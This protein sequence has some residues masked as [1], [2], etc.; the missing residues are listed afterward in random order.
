MSA[1][2]AAT[3]RPRQINHHKDRSCGFWIK[4][5][6]VAAFA[7]LFF[8]RFNSTF[9]P[10]H[11]NIEHR[12]SQNGFPV[13]YE[14]GYHIVPTPTPLPSWDAR[15]L[16]EKV[17]GKKW[18]Y[19]LNPY[20]LVPIHYICIRKREVE[21]FDVD[22]RGMPQNK[23][24]MRLLNHTL[25]VPHNEFEALLSYAARNF[26]DHLLTLLPEQRDYFLVFPH[27]KKSERWVAELLLRYLII[28][29]LDAT[30]IDNLQASLSKYPHVKRIVIADDAAY[31]CSSMSL[32]MAKTYSYFGPL[33]IHAIIPL[34]SSRNCL[35]DSFKEMLSYPRK[36]QPHEAVVHTALEFGSKLS[37]T[38]IFQNA[39]SATVLWLKKQGIPSPWLERYA[40]AFSHKL[41]DHFSI[42]RELYQLDNALGQDYVFLED[43]L[44]PYKDAVGTIELDSSEQQ[45][46]TLLVNEMMQP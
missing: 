19:E 46:V 29:P 36:P 13:C 43:P 4:A 23:P 25:V 21:R 1:A 6:I 45:L 26:T 11:F 34:M 28:L 39:D 22:A 17:K 2:I 35:H 20:P 42:P 12:E 16:T 15:A 41:P 40:L 27:P 24:V 8:S 10:Q 32:L 5:L 44:P 9:E 31:S 14:E 37:M 30:L 7:L 38:A 33:T 18:S 3:T